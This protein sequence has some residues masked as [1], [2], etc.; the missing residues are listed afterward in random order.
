MQKVSIK[1]D[2]PGLLPNRV[3]SRQLGAKVNPG[4][5]A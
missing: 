1:N 2:S 4:L 3:P 5:R